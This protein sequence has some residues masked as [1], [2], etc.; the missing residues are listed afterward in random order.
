[1]TPT[2]EMLRA[3]NGFLV[4]MGEPEITIPTGEEPLP[5][6][7]YLRQVK[8]DYKRRLLEKVPR[9]QG[10]PENLIGDIFL[11]A[12]LRREGELSEPDQ[13]SG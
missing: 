13:E 1:M 12:L 5:E 6:L 2:E 3:I 7:T 11:S 4:E 8:E 9:Y 10:L